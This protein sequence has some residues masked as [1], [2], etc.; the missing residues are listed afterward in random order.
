MRRKF[1]WIFLFLGLP[2]VAL[3][4]Q[5]P[6]PIRTQ[7]P[8]YLQTV[9][10]LPARAEV[11]APGEMEWRIDSAY[12]NLYE[13]ETGGN[14]INLDMELWRV[15][16]VAQYGFAPDWEV[17]LE[18]PTLHFEGGFLD[19][20]IQD[21]HDAFGFPNGGRESVANGTFN[22]RVTRNGLTYTVGS[23]ALDI[24]DL[25]LT[26]K[27]QLLAEEEGLPG[28]AWIFAFKFPSGDADAGLG[29]GNP[30][31][32][33][34]AALE[35]SYRRLH[36]YLNLNFLID[37]G[38]DSIENLT[39]KEFFDFS[40][41]GEF[42]FSKKVSALV[43]F[44][45]GTPRLK[46]TNLETWDGVPLDFIVGARGSV[47]KFFWQAAFSEDIRAVG[48]SVDFTTWISVGYRFGTTQLYQG[49]FLAKNYNF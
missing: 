12:S 35:K 31:F 42:S 8:I 23:Q 41:A 4:Q 14:D 2:C 29:S 5:G 6:F 15:A 1:Y 49:D 19:G 22:Y 9:T 39:Y 34:G 36:G 13:R 26:L 33:L 38:N 16:W 43:Q 7:H 45:G 21:F 18:I 11:L 44:V 10:I 30:G 37:G 27:N 40:L 25:T 24:G 3:A 28:L 20:F 17:G 46:G 47:G 48:P 32:G